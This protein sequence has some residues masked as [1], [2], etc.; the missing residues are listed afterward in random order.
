MLTYEKKTR[1]DAADLPE[2]LLYYK[3][4]NLIILFVYYFPNI[5]M[6][7]YVQNK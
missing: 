4:N 2:L 5:L 3:I 7:K 6:I 1:R